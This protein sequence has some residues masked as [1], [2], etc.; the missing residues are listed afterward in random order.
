[1]LQFEQRKDCI[2]FVLSCHITFSTLRQSCIGRLSCVIDT[3]FNLTKLHWLIIFV[4]RLKP[5]N[6][7]WKTLWIPSIPKDLIP[8]Y[9]PDLNLSTDLNLSPN[10]LCLQTHQRSRRRGRTNDGVDSCIHHLILDLIFD[11]CVNS[12]SKTPSWN[13]MRRW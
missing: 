2:N 12:I 8:S 5:R 10:R 6:L 4:I 11:H 1:M 13:H 7:Q 9:L 3:F